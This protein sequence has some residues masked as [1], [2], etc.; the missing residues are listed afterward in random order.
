MKGFVRV[1]IENND[2]EVLVKIISFSN[3]SQSIIQGSSSASVKGSFDVNCSS[4]LPTSLQCPF[5]SFLAKQL[6][7]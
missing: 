4:N 2:I 7:E 6:S 5:V 1:S 3:R